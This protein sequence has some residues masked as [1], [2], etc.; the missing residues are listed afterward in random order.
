MSKKIIVL[1]VIVVALLAVVW[2]MN[3]RRAVGGPGDLDYIPM[4][5]VTPAVDE[6]MM[7]VRDDGLS[8]DFVPGEV[9]E[10]LIA[11]SWQWVHTLMN[12][13]SVVMPIRPEFFVVTFEAHGFVYASTDCNDGR[14]SFRVSEFDDIAIGPLA[15]TMMACIHEDDQEYIF[16][17]DLSMVNKYLFDDEGNLVLNLSVDSGAMIF[18]PVPLGTSADPLSLGVLDLDSNAI[19]LE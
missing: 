9:P 13:D 18:A 4:E 8:L 14:G 2:V 15:T 10:Q 6:D 11:Y 12:D 7:G 16:L 1:I 5:A 17:R 3:E 19:I